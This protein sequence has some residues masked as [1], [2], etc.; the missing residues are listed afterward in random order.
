MA[1][2]ILQEDQESGRFVFES[3]T[4]YQSMLIQWLSQFLPVFMVVSFF[5]LVS[6]EQE[7]FAVMFVVF[8]PIFFLAWLL[9]WIGRHPWTELTFDPKLRILTKTVRPL[10]GQLHTSVLPFREMAALQVLITRR[11]SSWRYYRFYT[12]ILV[13]IRRKEMRLN[14]GIDRDE[15]NGLAQRISATTGVPIKAAEFSL[16]AP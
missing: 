8:T 5:V 7:G 1:A 9:S 14:E 4:D 13:D 6:S 10:L 11:A 16:W 2:L 3:S 15:I 12:L